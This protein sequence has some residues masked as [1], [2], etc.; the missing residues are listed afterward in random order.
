LTE[1]GTEKQK[2]RKPADDKAARRA[3]IKGAVE[4]YKAGHRAR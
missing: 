3:A 4:K 1:V 2:P